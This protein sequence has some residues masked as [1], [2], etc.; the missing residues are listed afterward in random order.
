MG[1]P[2]LLQ[3]AIDAHRASVLAHGEDDETSLLLAAKVAELR[4]ARDEQRP[5]AH[6]ISA[7]SKAL[8]KARAAMQRAR[9]RVD[10]LEEALLLAR[11]A[12][13]EA[14]RALEAAQAKHDEVLAQGTAP[15]PAGGPLPMACPLLGLATSRSAEGAQLQELWERFAKDFMVAASPLLAAARVDDLDDESDDEDA[16][17]AAAADAVGQVD[18]A[19]AGATAEALP[20]EVK[21]ALV[22]QVAEVAGKRRRVAGA[23]PPKAGQSAAAP[24][25]AAC[26]A[27]SPP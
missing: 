27:G 2:S 22:Q 23:A 6:R 10:E 17:M 13:D 1:E 14:T 8:E 15:S 24:P 11:P 12:L 16:P 20:E 19:A 5:L 25:Q 21:R 26:G 18:W 7:S 4:Q 3:R 9:G